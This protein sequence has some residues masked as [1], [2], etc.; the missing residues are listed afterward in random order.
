MGVLRPRPPGVGCYPIPPSIPPSLPPSLPPF[1]P[2]SQPASQP[3]NLGGGVVSG[4]AG[5]WEKGMDGGSERVR[6][7]GD[8]APPQGEGGREGRR[9]PERA[10]GRASGEALQRLYKGPAIQPASQP[11]SQ[12][13]SGATVVEPH[14]KK[15]RAF[16]QSLWREPLERALSTEPCQPPTQQM[17]RLCGGSVEGQPSSQPASQPAR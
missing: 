12:P 2:T 7:G 15:R 1:Q 6:E 14:V 16:R 11:A 4:R 5:R 3:A 8:P 17:Q 13:G 10:S 9:G